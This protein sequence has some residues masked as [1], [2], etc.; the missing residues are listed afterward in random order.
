MQLDARLRAFAAV[1]RQGS[2]SRAAEEIFV[3]Q[4]AV[5]KH[6]AAL[7]AELGARLVQRG[8]GGAVLT[9][10][11]RMLADYVLRAEALLS[12]ARR[13]VAAADDADS[14]TVRVAASGVPGDYLL[15]AVLASFLERNPRADVALCVTTSAGALRLV[16]AHE[17]EVAVIGGFAV[18]GDLEAEPLIEDEI[19]LVG[20]P[21]LAGRRLRPRDLEHFVWIGREEGSG[22]RAAVDAARWQIGIH[23]VRTLELSSWEAVKGAV[24]AGAGVAAISRYA[25]SAELELGT[26]ALLDAPRWRLRRTISV[27]TAREVPLSPAARRFRR[28]L[29]D[30]DFPLL[31]ADDGHALDDQGALGRLRVFAGGFEAEAADDVCG[32][33]SATLERLV[34]R[35]WITRD[36]RRYDAGG[37]GAVADEALERRHAEF[38]AAFV[39]ECEPHLHALGHEE[40]AAMLE[41]EIENIDAA[42]RWA[43]S[44]DAHE[45]LVRLIGGAW[46]FWLA[47]GHAARWR[48]PLEGALEGMVDPHLRLRALPTVGWLALGDGDFARADEI[49]AERIAVGEE[50]GDGAS[51]AGGLTMRAAAASAAGDAAQAR[52]FTEEAVAVDR[53]SGVTLR[54]NE[55]LVNLAIHQLEGGDLDGAEASAREAAALALGRGDD[56]LAADA[57]LSLA[58]A[59]LLRGKPARA[60]AHA[61]L[62]A[63]GE[64]NVR[65]DDYWGVV[66]IAGA[67]LVGVDR[68]ELG[69]RLLAAAEAT[70]KRTGADRTAT[71]ASLS[72]AALTK[73]RA[74]LAGP[75]FAREK[76]RGARTPIA[77]ALEL[78]GSS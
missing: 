39:E 74:A 3:S 6:V 45:L 31:V 44:A 71:F 5:S 36:G 21:A 14:G 48:D 4:P 11:G 28:A 23:E 32:V 73:A 59:A 15:P 27:V 75:D 42:V 40:W 54:L 46:R 35:G 1:A 8:R 68:F 70:R 56:V 26:L 38:Y 20:P 37:R 77:R 29:R 63:T 57:A 34:G 61:R 51:V 47:G 43:S 16:R 24:A 76:R 55:H 66:E 12:S 58:V 33:D 64:P 52:R 13:A 50:V 49:G 60:L 9:P 19:V 25:V 78:L 17:V 65:L 53:R 41:R 30:H 67:A 18:T 69:V 72:D 62:A 7:E 22:T 2:F 10:T